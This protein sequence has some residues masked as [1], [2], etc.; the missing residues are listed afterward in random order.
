MPLSDR[1]REIWRMAMKDVKPLGSSCAP[2]PIMNLPRAKPPTKDIQ[3]WDL[4]GMTLDQAHELTLR[5]VDRHLGHKGS[6]TFITGK[7]GQIN[8]EF[9][10]WLDRYPGVKT[11]ESINGGGAYRVWFTKARQKRK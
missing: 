11:V 5:E 4:H 7:S 2:D 1:D 6:V 8:Q 10:H 9:Q 3:M